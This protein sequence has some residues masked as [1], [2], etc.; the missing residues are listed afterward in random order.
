V[1]DGLGLAVL[2]L[3]RETQRA[4]NNFETRLAGVVGAA[5]AA[6]ALPDVR[7]ERQEEIA[8]IPEL[9]ATPMS[10]GEIARHVGYDEA[11]TYTVLRS[12]EK[13]GVLEVVGDSPRRW[14]LA[15]VHRSNKVIQAS[16]VLEPGEWATY[17]DMAIAV[18]GNVNMARTIGQ[19][20]AKNPGFANPHRV[21]AAGG[22][23]PDGWRGFGGGPEECEKRLRR[24]KV[25]F[26]D[27]TADSA[28][29]VGYEEIKRRLDRVPDPDED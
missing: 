4:L 7:G 28:Q 18:Y 9:F 13:S 5:P 23:I 24:E 12:L 29:Q 10:A 6:E 21:L 2:D 1:D 3:V 22:Q 8:R 17:G 26:V 27:G 11:N 25:R 14:R 16:H 20:A 15:R 19:V